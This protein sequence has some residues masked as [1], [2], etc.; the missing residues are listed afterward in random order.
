M[1]ARTPVLAAPRPQIEAQVRPAPSLRFDWT[2]AIL[3]LLFVGGIY[4]DAWAH[5]HGLVDRSFFTPW[6]AALYSGFLI[7]ALFVVTTMLVNMQRGY[8][9]QRTLPVGYELLPLGVLIFA[10]GG[11]GDMLWHTFVGREQGTEGLLS[12]THQTL[13]VGMLLICSSPLRSDWRQTAVAGRGWLMRL[14]MVVSLTLVLAA[15]N[16]ETVFV[17]PLINTELIVFS[18][19]RGSAKLIDLGIAGILIQA[20]LTMGL[21]LL[22]LRHGPLPVGSLTL[23][24]TITTAMISTLE[25]QYRLIPPALVAG[26]CADLLLVWLRPSIA[27]PRALRIFAFAVPAIVSACYLG[28]LALTQ[29]FG[30]STHLWAGSI[31]G[32]GVVGLLLSYLVTPAQPAPAVE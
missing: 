8:A 12:P 19:V 16:L 6:H 15:L 4:F 5:Y 21:L 30:W 20:G 22:T 17:N 2:I 25:D 24:L 14:P 31:M 7:V 29:Q 13:I 3:G 18:D 32:A 27:R 10:A 26:L 9:W 28:G 11:V 23:M 1:T